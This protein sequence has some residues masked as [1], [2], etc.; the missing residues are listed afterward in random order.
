MAAKPYPKS[1][2][3]C[4]DGTSNNE[5]S[6]TN[7]HRLYRHADEIPGKQ[8]KCYVTGLGADWDWNMIGGNFAGKGIEGKLWKGYDFLIKNCSRANPG[9]DKLTVVGF[10]RGAF[11]A[12]CFVTFLND[13]GFSPDAIKSEQQFIKLFTSWRETRESEPRGAFNKQR[14]LSDQPENYK[15]N[16]FQTLQ[17]SALG[18]F[19]TVAALEGGRLAVM[20]KPTRQ[21]LAFIDGI[22]PP[23]VKNA[24]HALSLFEHRRDFGPAVWTKWP[25]KSIVRQCWFAGCHS[26]VGGFSTNT[27]PIHHFALLW[28]MG[29]LGD[30]VLFNTWNLMEDIA[31][32]VKSI[33]EKYFSDSYDGKILFIP[34]AWHVAG[35]ENRQ[36]PTIGRPTEEQ[37]KK[38]EFITLKGQTR[39]IL[40][41]H[42]IHWTT[43]SFVAWMADNNRPCHPLR[44]YTRHEA[45]FGEGVN[46]ATGEDAGPCYWSDSKA[47]VEEEMPSAFE[48]EFLWTWAYPNAQ[49]KKQTQQFINKAGTAHRAKPTRGQSLPPGMQLS[50]LNLNPGTSQANSQKASP[51]QAPAV[52]TTDQTAS[53]SITTTSSS[54][55]P[56]GTSKNPKPSRNP[57]RSGS[58]PVTPSKTS[59]SSQAKPPARAPSTPRTAPIKPVSLPKSWPQRNPDS[60]Q[61]K[62]AGPPRPKPWKYVQGGWWY[63]EKR[64]VVEG[65]KLAG[66]AEGRARGKDSEVAYVG[67]AED[68]SEIRVTMDTL[69][70][71]AARGDWGYFAG[72]KWYVFGAEGEEEG[73]RKRFG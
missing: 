35:S 25:A 13:V 57:Q 26:D 30:F 67:M 10:S 18:L 60:Q 34:K 39:P 45:D 12:S 32:S 63:L 64:T 37:V 41:N 62:G 5:A 53:T 48:F 15:V 29:M 16:D 52:K 14:F 56:S 4:F 11:T 71:D 51:Q 3:V 6:G 36:L 42:S 7:I 66:G 23:N 8:A 38:S 9:A 17:V 22:V 33:S 1:L 68:G 2:L 58:L 31:S 43:A 49:R 27:H 40:E 73:P 59:T 20:P 70:Y 44:A 46:P 61:H 50:S 55:S 19:D 69:I 21:K 28:M 54:S 24:Y 47:K 72:K 65:W